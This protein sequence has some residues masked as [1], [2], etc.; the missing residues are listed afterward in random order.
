MAK[1]S[2]VYQLS[3]GMWGFRYAYWVGGKQKDIKRTKDKNGN[4]FLTKAAALKARKAAI[5]ETHSERTQKPAKP[6]MTV[7]E[8]FAEYCEN[9]RHGKAFGTTRKQ[10]S[11]WKN[12]ISKK[13]GKRYVD[14]ISVSEVNDYLSLL[15]HQEDR[16]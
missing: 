1:S 13:F 15:Y 6:R 10:D 14:D 11:L 4:P 16:A 5:I 2:G 3:N 12:H 7:A 8:V 9:G